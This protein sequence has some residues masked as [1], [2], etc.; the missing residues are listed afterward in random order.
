MRQGNSKSRS[1]AR[2]GAA[3]VLSALLAPLTAAA[4]PLFPLPSGQDLTLSGSS[5]PRTVQATGNNPAAPVTSDLGGFWF[6][7]GGAGVGYEAGDFNDLITQF[8]QLE[9]DLNKENQT[10]AEATALKTR[11]DAFLQQLGD[12]GTIKL[13]TSVQPPFLPLGGK[14]SGLGGA[15][16]LGVTAH[17]GARINVLSDGVDVCVSDGVDSNPC[18]APTGAPGE[19]YEIQ[20]DT[21]G[22]GKAAGGGS[23][24][25]GY[26]GGVHHRP[27]GSLF[28]G[29][30]LNYY[31]VELARAVVKL[32]DNGDQMG[33]DTN[34]SLQDEFDRG[35]V[36]TSA[37]GLDL[38]FLWAA[39]NFRAGATLRNLN[40][41]E[42]EY[43]A[44]GVDCGSKTG[45]AM[46]NCIAAAE[47]IAA[48]RIPAQETYTMEQQIQLETA[49]FTSNRSWSLAATY[50]ADAIRDASGD[51]YQ[52]LGVSAAFSPRGWGWLM[53][54]LRLG[55]RQNQAG[56]ELDMVSLG[57]TLFRVINL[58]VAASTQTV[59]DEGDEAPRSAMANLSFELFF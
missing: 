56:S 23:V 10:P 38:G 47:F 35:R 9:A 1:L 20:T 39:H 3:L 36:R 4:S 49:V 8:E 13:F 12:K 22:Y 55:Y 19:T 34:D 41:P 31:S 43:G 59:E 51:E 16:T 26:S 2:T 48:G 15:W 21:S 40:E 52:W 45:A 18:Q 25:L 58:D 37:V 6:G 5:N 27:D 11:A 14:A 42:F 29:G 44:L 30:R 32:E 24:S 17:A 33:D 57:L 7:L 54:G 28:V 46:R 53:P 50:D